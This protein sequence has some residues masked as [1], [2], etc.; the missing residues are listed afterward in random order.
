[1][2]GDEFFLPPHWEAIEPLLDRLLATDPARRRELLVEITSA[3]TEQRL[4]IEQ[5]LAECERDM[6][7]LE[8][9]AIERFADVARVDDDSLAFVPPAV[10]GGR[11]RLGDE[12][13]QGGMARVFLAE[14][15]RHARSVAVKVIRPELSA[16]LGRERFLREIGMVARLRHPN[17]MPL[18]DSGDD[19]GVLYYVMPLETGASLKA[20]LANGTPIPVAEGLSILRD[21]LRAL[22]HAHAEGIV[23]RDIKPANVMLS[24]GAAVVADFGIGKAITAARG[25][26]DDQLTSEGAIIGTPAYMAPEQATGAPGVDHRADL[27]SFGCLAYAVL[28]GSPPFVGT[29][30]EVLAG[31]LGAPPPPLESRRAD[32]PTFVAPIVEQCLRKNPAERPSSAH[33]VLEMLTGPLVSPA[34]SHHVP[35]VAVGAVAVS[36]VAVAL[37]VAVVVW[38]SMPDRG[39][40]RPT[41]SASLSPI[42]VVPFRNVQRDTA[43]DY[44]ATALPSQVSQAL[45]TLPDV[46]PFATSRDLG[47]V[48]DSTRRES[49]KAVGVRTVVEGEVRS[50]GDSVLVDVT[51]VDVRS[52]ETRFR[53]RAS[54]GTL[55]FASLVGLATDSLRGRLGLARPPAAP[56]HIPNQEAFRLVSEA[57]H[58]WWLDP[59]NPR[60]LELFS[61]ASELDPQWYRP[62]VGMSDYAGRRLVAQAGTRSDMSGAS[63]AVRYGEM[64]L[65]R[66]GASPVARSAALIRSALPRF[67]L[68]D[69]AASRADAQLA[70]SLDST[71]F[72]TQSLIGAWFM[73]SGQLDSAWKYKSRA[74]R[75]APWNAG[76][77]ASLAM[78]QRCAGNATQE[79][80]LLARAIELQPRRETLL[81][82][83]AALAA[84]G[85]F[86]SAL[87]VWER[88]T[89]VD[90]VRAI[91]ARTGSARGE[92]QWR[93]TQEL[94]A[95]M[96][97][98]RLRAQAPPR[99][100]YLEWIESFWGTGQ[101]DSARAVLSEWINSGTPKLSLQRFCIHAL[102]DFRRD[103]QVLALVR[104]SAWPLAEFDA[105]RMR[106]LAPSLR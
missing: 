20:R 74:Q 22:A 87:V 57:E 53:V 96:R 65:E 45:G 4:A 36:A 59:L 106:A 71:D 17:I 103:A 12:L 90:E 50:V 13:G 75:L 29:A 35:R 40:A 69:L 80:Q 82:R 93:R 85:E 91:R 62:F 8:G 64:A 61:K 9:T 7:L 58:L 38:R 42:A 81:R 2:N 76:E 56:L 30:Q 105:E 6:P 92:T 70:A 55:Q 3:D 68:G 32:L 19:D 51:V 67:L 54:A 31:H 10:L 88:A 72:Q 18:F 100:L 37:A 44:M 83:A 46:V 104:A 11:Y 34:R 23:H 52:G 60:I 25:S 86:D 21:V 49:L 99:R 97:L 73:W 41:L 95:R 79:N 16:S 66:A 48:A 1:M 27:Y 84:A 102:D 5:L 24:G 94:H 15:I 43:L 98:D 63:A 26:G 28:T 33:D 77:L 89:P 47:S 101:R 78:L 39:A 14:D